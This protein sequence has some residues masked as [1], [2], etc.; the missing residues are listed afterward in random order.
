MPQSTQNM[1]DTRATIDRNAN[2][3][4]LRRSFDAPRE[5]IFS[6]W[7][8]PK[9]VAV[10]WDAAGAP[11]ARCE[12]DLRVGGTFTFVSG[13]ENVPP[14]TGAY[15]KIE[16]PE[17]LAFEAMGALGMVDL[18][19]ENGRTEM[20]VTIKCPTAEHLENFLMM[21]VNEGTAETLDNLVNFIKC[22][23]KA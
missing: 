19:E 5:I 22:R 16:R 20:V 1:L 11:L 13:S 7:T 6:A 18:Q 8:D 21:R 23:Q 15:R 12:I 3:I 17:H 4:I 9:Q 14:F 10:W 2:A